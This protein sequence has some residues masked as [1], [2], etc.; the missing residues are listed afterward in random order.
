M[1]N[2]Q[3][4]NLLI[5]F[6]SIL[7]N[8]IRWAIIGRVLF[9]WFKMGAHSGR[10]RMEQFLYDITDPFIDLAKKIPHQVGFLDL[11]PIIALIGIDLLSQLIIKLLIQTVS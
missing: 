9:S 7:A 4:V 6:I 1:N 10:G 3:L 5:S 11:S 2:V 8:I